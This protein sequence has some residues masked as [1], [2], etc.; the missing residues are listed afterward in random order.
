VCVGG[1]CTYVVPGLEPQEGASW[2][3]RAR[4]AVW[5]DW[6]ARSSFIVEAEAEEVVLPAPLVVSPTNG[7]SL[8]AGVPIVLSF[9]E[10]SDAVRYQVQ[11][12]DSVSS[13]NTV[14]DTNVPTSVCSN[15]VCTLEVPGLGE[16]EG[17]SWRVRA[18][19][20]EWSDWSARASFIVEAE[21]EEVIPSAPILSS[22]IRETCLFDGD[23]FCWG[24]YG[25]VINAGAPPLQ[26]PDI[27]SVAG[28]HA[29]ALEEGSVKCWGFNTGGLLDIPDFSNVKALSASTFFNC[30]AND[31]NVVCWGDETLAGLNQ[32]GAPYMEGIISIQTGF[33]HSCALHANGVSCWGR[34]NNFGVLDVPV[35]QNP[36]VLGEQSGSRN[37]CAIDDLG[38]ICWGDETYNVPDVPPLTNPVMVSLAV[39]HAC[40]L[41]DEGVVCWGDNSDGQLEVPSLINPIAVSVG[42]GY[43][44][45][46][47]DIGVVCWGDDSDGQIS[48]QPVF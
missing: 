18:R 48:D 13:S 42:Q 24:F 6:S 47:D 32:S 43:S 17:S 41:T 36:R 2:R 31:S 35:L 5:G 12:Y 21:A 44:C 3:V 8:P 40:A 11:V 14:N 46:A 29:C 16:Q 15:G 20:D 28:S 1:V 45:A 38:V 37:V 33:D 25:P 7:E 19:G 22:G 30:A 9:S 26:S 39:T 4:G 34:S 10:V 23:L 27:V